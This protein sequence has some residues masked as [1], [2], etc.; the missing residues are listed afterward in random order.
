MRERGFVLNRGLYLGLYLSIFPFIYFAFGETISLSMYFVVFWGV[1]LLG[2]I[3]LLLKFGKEF[4]ANCDFFN[5]KQSFT[6]LYLISSVALVSLFITRSILWTGLY[7]EKYIQLD[8][9]FNSEF[10]GDALIGMAE[11][12]INDAYDLSQISD[13]EY[14]E[15]T[16]NLDTYKKELNEAMEKR[17]DDGLLFKFFLWELIKDLFLFAIINVILALIIRRKINH[18]IR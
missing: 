17:W 18:E 3:F 15:Q 2:V 16:E 6:V 8:K 13:E 1:W 7:P 14:Q 5:F 10:Y 4:R 12:K 9:D 11:E